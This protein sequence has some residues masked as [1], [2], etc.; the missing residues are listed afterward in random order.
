MSYDLNVRHITHTDIDLYYDGMVELLQAHLEWHDFDVDKFSKWLVRVID[1]PDVD[2]LLC[3]D[4]YLP[5]G[6]FIART[7]TPVWSHERFSSD[8][9][10]YVLP[11]YR[12]KGA[13]VALLQQWT[14]NLQARGVKKALSGYS[15]RASHSH[16]RAAYKK[17][18]FFTLGEIYARNL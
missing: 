7:V 4:G 2:T 17:A 3:M 9:V 15:L 16:A 8:V 1:D 13:A 18:K 6:Y 10:L 12:G 14:Y 5:A 11:P